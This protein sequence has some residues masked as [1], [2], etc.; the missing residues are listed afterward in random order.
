MEVEGCYVVSLTSV[1]RAIQD[2][3]R[4]RGALCTRVHRS[5]R[6][7]CPESFAIGGNRSKRLRPGGAQIH[8]RENCRGAKESSGCCG[9]RR[10]IERQILNRRTY[11]GLQNLRW[12]L[13]DAIVVLTHE[14]LESQDE[15]REDMRW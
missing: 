15:I 2:D 14:R 11:P 13:K 10:A 4:A 5:Q 7:P 6:H 9:I 8:L 12:G 3:C 1:F